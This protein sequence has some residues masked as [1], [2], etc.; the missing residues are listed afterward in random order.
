MSKRWQQELHFDD[1]AATATVGIKALQKQ[2]V[3]LL[4]IKVISTWCQETTKSQ[5]NLL[6]KAQ[7]LRNKEKS[8]AIPLAELRVPCQSQHCSNST[9]QALP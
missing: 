3:W 1:S 5:H 4:L 6:S 7:S 8:G 2:M 9:S